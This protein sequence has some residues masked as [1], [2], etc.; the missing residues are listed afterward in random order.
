MM[1]VLP[2]ALER[3]PASRA[4]R[5]SGGWYC[6]GPT[7]PAFCCRCCLVLQEIKQRYCGLNNCSRTARIWSKH[8][9][10][11]KVPSSLLP[12][13]LQGWTPPAIAALGL[14]LH[15]AARFAESGA[16]ALGMEQSSLG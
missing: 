7:G 3:L 15:V 8:P 12:F 14:F 2:S 5:C 10:S 9:E 4:H 13:C 11:S 1:H 16:G 6:M